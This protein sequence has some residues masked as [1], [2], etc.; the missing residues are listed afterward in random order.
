MDRKI[1]GAIVVTG[2]SSG[3]GRE[4]AL[5]LASIGYKVF[6]CARIDRDLEELNRLSQNSSFKGVLLPIKLDIT[7]KN[8]IEEAFKSINDQVGT[9]GLVGLINN[10]GVSGSLR[11][12]E[13]TPIEEYENV[14]NVNFISQ[15]RITKTF[16]QLLRVENGTIVFITS[17]SS[18]LPLALFTSYGASKSALDMFSRSLTREFQYIGVHSVSFIVGSVKS[19]M[20]A[21]A[22]QVGTEMKNKYSDWPAHYQK[23]AVEIGHWMKK[24]LG[25]EAYEPSCVAEKIELILRDSSPT[26]TYFDGNYPPRFLNTL[27]DTILEWSF[28]QILKV[29]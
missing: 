12:F 26:S 19:R 1:G 22:S 14:I 2:A 25:D 6:A 16:F 27:T 21:Y 4:T 3:I 5:H 15:L 10:A 29:I 28:S 9:D 7:N 13:L 24:V 20:T 18:Y 17:P 11:P 23:I 8:H